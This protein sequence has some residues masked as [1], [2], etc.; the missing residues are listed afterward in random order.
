MPN[1]IENLLKITELLGGEV[2]HLRRIVYL[3]RA[4]IE[5]LRSYAVAKIADLSVQERAKE[6]EHVQKMTRLL[7]EQNILKIEKTNPALAAEIDVREQAGLSQQ[8]KELWYLASEDF[9]KLSEDG[10]DESGDQ[11]S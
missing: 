5:A 6:Y 3:Q 2:R 7:Y 8:E 4:E 10:S 1:E 11:K 9:P